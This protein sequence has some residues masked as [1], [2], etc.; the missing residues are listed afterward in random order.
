[1]GLKLRVLN[2]VVVALAFLGSV[3]WTPLQFQGR[4]V[5]VVNNLALD[6]K[7]AADVQWGEEIQIQI[8]IFQS[9]VESGQFLKLDFQDAEQTWIDGMIK[10][11]DLSE[12]LEALKAISGRAQNL[13]KT[14]DLEVALKLSRNQFRDRAEDEFLMDTAKVLGSS[15]V[16]VEA[17]VAAVYP[18]VKDWVME[19]AISCYL[20]MKDQL[21]SQNPEDRLYFAERLLGQL[22]QTF[23][24]MTER[25]VH[26]GKIQAIYI[27][28]LYLKLKKDEDFS[29]DSLRLFAESLDPVA[30]ASRNNAN[31]A[32]A[33][34]AGPGKKET[35]NSPNLLALPA[36][37]KKAANPPVALKAD[38]EELSSEEKEIDIEELRARVLSLL[39]TNVPKGFQ[40]WTA[41][42]LQMTLARLTTAN[43]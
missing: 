35:K 39:G 41:E 15:A 36:P 16:E 42:R 6:P 10:S 11:A 8:G 31:P 14:D 12:V 22:D 37:P 7:V 27:K 26:D 20:R 4:L 2:V 33:D 24:M 17:A 43:K 21:D 29:L 38:K 23:D 40:D 13:K 32:A 9:L 19:E 34:V 25:L 28:P 18:L 3:A 30:F 1:M 5:P